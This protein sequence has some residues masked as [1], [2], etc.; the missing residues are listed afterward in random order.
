V[1][2][3]LFASKLLPA[4]AG[5]VVRCYLLSYWGD[6]PVA[7]TLTAG[8]IVRIMDGVWL[9][10]LYYFAIIGIQHVPRWL[11]SGMDVVTLVVVALAALFLYVLFR[12][13]HAHT[14]ASGNRWACKFVHILDELH[15]LGNREN[16][17]RALGVSFL[18]FALQVL[19]FWA[20]FKAYHFDFGVKDSSFVLIVIH[21]GTMV[22]NAPGNIGSL[23][24]FCESALKILSA[25]ASSAVSFST[26][27]FVFLTLPQLVGGAIAV[28]LTGFNIQQLHQHAREA[29]HKHHE[30]RK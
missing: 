6:I 8:V 19:F 20:L 12:R 25:E 17:V 15:K 4:K 22:P 14:W 21:L 23:Q 27:M 11:S 28:A 29:H 16:L 26:I 10:I 1:Y 13:S 24:F 3:G 7:L 9:V 30:R 18:Y 5:E 2:V